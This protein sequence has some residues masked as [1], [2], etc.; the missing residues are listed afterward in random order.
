MVRR[1]GRK[2]IGEMRRKGRKEEGEEVVGYGEVL[3]G[4]GLGRKGLSK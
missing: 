4:D 1:M 3:R 2:G